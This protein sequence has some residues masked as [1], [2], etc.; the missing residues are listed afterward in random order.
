MN[1]NEASGYWEVN[2]DDITLNDRPQSVCAS[3]RVA[4]DTGTSQLAGPTDVIEKLQDLIDIHS[5]CSNFDTLPKLGFVVDSH[6]LNLEPRDYVDRASHGTSCSLSLMALDVP[7]PKG[8]LFVLGI[9]F[10]QRYYT[11]YDAAQSRVGFAVARHVG[12]A[13]ASLAT[14]AIHNK[15]SELSSFR[16]VI[17]E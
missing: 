7:P 5:D 17:H 14:I 11:V 9:P 15:A 2:I 3:C 1:V 4:V 16:G 8:P 10:L 12:V 6:P 13:P